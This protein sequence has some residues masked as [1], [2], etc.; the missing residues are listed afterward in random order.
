MNNSARKQTMHSQFTIEW[1][2]L[3]LTSLLIY[4]D[5]VELR[6]ESRKWKMSSLSFPFFVN[7]YEKVGQHFSFFFSFRCAKNIQRSSTI[8]SNKQT[9]WSLSYVKN[10]KLQ[11][12]AINIWRQTNTN[13]WM[14]VSLMNLQTILNWIDGRWIKSV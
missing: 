1:F 2:F 8:F 4:V 14:C 10:W 13:E 5:W 6:W 12:L 9:N 7:E 3:H 11:Q